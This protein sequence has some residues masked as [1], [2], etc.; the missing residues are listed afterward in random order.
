MQIHSKIPT[1]SVVQVFSPELISPEISFSKIFY[2]HLEHL[3]SGTSESKCYSFFYLCF[4]FFDCNVF[5]WLISLILCFFKTSDPV[6]ISMSDQRCFNVEITLIR[7]WKWN[8]IFNVHMVDTSSVPD[9]ETTLRNDET[10]LYQGCFNL[11]SMLVKA[12][13][14]PIGLVMIMDLQIHE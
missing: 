1:I 5:F 14:N 7:R 3:L 2:T 8:K 11:T 9:V 10:T 12:I 6:N 13:L 4:Y